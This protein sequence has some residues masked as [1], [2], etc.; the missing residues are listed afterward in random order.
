MLSCVNEENEYGNSNS[1]FNL[2]FTKE[3]P[4]IDFN[5]IDNLNSSNQ[6]IIELSSVSFDSTKDVKL[7]RLLLKIKK[8]H[9]KIDSELNNLA[10]KNLIIIPKV[11]DHTNTD[12]IK[13]LSLFK[14]LKTEIKNQITT[15]DRIESTTQNIDFKIFAKKSKKVILGNNEELLAL[16]QKF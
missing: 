1:L 13:K 2:E 10:N 6:K 16:L 8:D 12:S 5:T 3:V 11:I 14:E 7:L 9:L 15:F 4:V